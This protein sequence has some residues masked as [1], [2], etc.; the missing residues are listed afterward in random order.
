MGMN[1]TVINIKADKEVKEAAQDI[2]RQLGMPLSTIINAYLRQFIRTKEIRFSL[3]GELKSSAK[4][5]LERLQKE[6]SEGRNLSR[7]FTSA[8]ESIRHLHSR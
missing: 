1:K 2:A 4:K 7:S 3:E 5:R 6:A 8:D